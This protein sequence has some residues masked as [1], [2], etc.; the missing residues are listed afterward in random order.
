[1]R[2]NL[3]DTIGSYLMEGGC[4]TPTLFVLSDMYEQKFLEFAQNALKIVGGPFFAFLC[5]LS[6]H[7]GSI[8]LL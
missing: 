1:M 2:E 8:L 3:C 6:H 4:L 7:Y 5:Q